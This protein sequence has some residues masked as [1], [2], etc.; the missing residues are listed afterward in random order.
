MYCIRRKEQTRYVVFYNISKNLTTIYRTQ[1]F[2]VQ[3][4]YEAVFSIGFLH[5]SIKCAFT[6]EAI[7]QIAA[8]FEDINQVKTGEPADE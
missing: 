2:C 3:V 4:L 1:F 8:H 7:K 6:A 5:P